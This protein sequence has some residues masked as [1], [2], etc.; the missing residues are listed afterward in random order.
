MQGG[1]YIRPLGNAI[2]LMPPYCITE[3]ELDTIYS[4]LEKLMQELI[5]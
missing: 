5:E 1:V 2:Y 3:E 4:C